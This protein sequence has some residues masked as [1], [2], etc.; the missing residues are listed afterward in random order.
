VG[1]G[2]RTVGPHHGVRP[3][4]GRGGH[5]WRFCRGSQKIRKRANGGGYSEWL[6]RARNGRGGE[7]GGGGAGVGEVTGAAPGAVAWVRGKI[8][9]GGPGAGTI[10]GPAGWGGGTA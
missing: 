6:L 7:G 2:D 8:F 1:G 10:R 9:L 5:E 4:S 3:G